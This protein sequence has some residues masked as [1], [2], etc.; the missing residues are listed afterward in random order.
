MPAPST[1]PP[2]AH[3]VWLGP[4]IK[5]LGYLAVRMA[6]DRGGF[7]RVVL[8][9]DDP[10]LAADPAVQDLVGRQRFTLRLV[11]PAALI[12]E[13]P[14][15]LNPAAAERLLHLD[16]T[17]AN[18]V[19]RSDI[20]RLL[21]LWHTG[22]VYLDTDMLVLQPFGPLLGEEGFAGRDEIAVPV[23]VVHSRNPLRHLRAKVLVEVRKQLG[24]RA[25]HPLRAYRRV[26]GLYVE[27]VDNAL[28][29]ARPGHPFIGEALERIARMP[30]A[31]VERLVGI[32]PH[33]LQRM[34]GNRSVPGFTLH[35]PERFYPLPPEICLLLVRDDPEGR[36]DGVFGGGTYAVHAY[37][38]VLAKRLR[39]QPDEA[40]LRARR[41]R[42]LLTRLT[43]PYL[44]D[45]F[46]A[47]G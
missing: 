16:R 8:H 30:Q 24:L 28:L 14:E 42:T 46:R 36:F 13:A 23:E 33:L 1:I 9:H 31:E 32:G 17:L 26:A 45:L 18:R 35:P 21:H 2:V 41:G 10:T 19:I 20:H 47:R 34:T 5:A 15:R 37:D 44:D 12:A 38:S 43:E 40:F 11:D 27:A 22:G 25:R 39:Q 3:F 4:R 7:E 29:A 6:L